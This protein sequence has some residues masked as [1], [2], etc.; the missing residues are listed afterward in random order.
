VAGGDGG[1]DPVTRA[2]RMLSF[3]FLFVLAVLL[4]LNIWASK[5]AWRFLHRLREN[6]ASTWVKLG[7]PRS[8]DAENSPA[9]NSLFM[10]IAFGRFHDLNDEVLSADGSRLQRIFFLSIGGLVLLF[11]LR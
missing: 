11:L 1:G 8:T 2:F 4:V 7:Q 5:I 6:F 10:F 3:L 9:N